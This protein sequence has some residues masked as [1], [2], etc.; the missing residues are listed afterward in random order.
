MLSLDLQQLKTKNIRSC[1]HMLREYRVPER[2]LELI[3]ICIM[4]CVI[5]NAYISP[6]TCSTN[7]RHEIQSK[8]CTVCI[9]ESERNPQLSSRQRESVQFYNI[10]SFVSDGETKVL[11]IHALVMLPTLL[12]GCTGYKWCSARVCDFTH[13]TQWPL[14]GPFENYWSS[15]L[16]AY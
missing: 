3:S 6:F 7:R 5:K 12:H 2:R 1:I 11:H 15:P 14:N 13:T 9:A 8:F 10:T 4:T 16:F